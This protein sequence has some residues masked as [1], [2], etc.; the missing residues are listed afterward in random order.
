MELWVYYEYSDGNVYIG[1]EEE[2]FYNLDNLELID[3]KVL[4]FKIIIDRYMNKKVIIGDNVDG[5]NILVIGGVH[6]DEL[7]PLYSVYL[8]Q[9]FLE[10]KNVKKDFNKLTIINGI[11]ESGIENCTRE[12]ENNSTQDLNRKLLHNNENILL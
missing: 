9:Q 7:T 2:D 6:G 4:N 12:M 3:D 5:K 11:N 1:A 8:Y 10:N